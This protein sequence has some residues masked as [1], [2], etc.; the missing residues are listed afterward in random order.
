MIIQLDKLEQDVLGKGGNVKVGQHFSG[1]F[2][3]RSMMT[4]KHPA[5]IQKRGQAPGANSWR[6]RDTEMT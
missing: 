3:F 1:V 6:G 2:L 5:Q 4:A